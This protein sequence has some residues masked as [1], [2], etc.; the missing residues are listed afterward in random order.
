M[1]RQIQRDNCLAQVGS[2]KLNFKISFHK[3]QFGVKRAASFLVISTETQF[4]DR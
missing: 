1:C 2:N 3:Q 4:G